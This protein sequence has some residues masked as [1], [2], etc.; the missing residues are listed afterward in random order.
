MALDPQIM[1]L[2]G[3]VI[4][5]SVSW[6]GIS[7]T[8]RAK[9]RRD[10]YA[11][12]QEHRMTAYADFSAAAKSTMS[13]LF[14][15]GAWLGVDRMTEP[16]S[17]EEARPLLANAFH[18]RETAF[19]RVRLVA[20]DSVVTAAR[21]WVRGTYGMRKLLESGEVDTESWA[22]LVAAANRGRDEF[23]EAAK[24]EMVAS[25]RSRG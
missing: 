10:Q 7:L 5:G 18:E 6:V 22:V 19:E 20:G 11:R 23:F 17:L 16:L 13:V 3:V 8:E 24:R 4:G 21:Q 12:L 25:E 9:F 2:V 14:R 15:V 1:T